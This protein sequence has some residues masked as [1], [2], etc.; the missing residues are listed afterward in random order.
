MEILAS[1]REFN[2]HNAKSVR[3]QTF[4]SL[5]TNGKKY[6]LGPFMAPFGASAW[7][8][9]LSLD[10]TVGDGFDALDGD[11]MRLRSHWAA[12]GILLSGAPLTGR[13]CD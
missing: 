10:L 7:D 1:A 8:K 5:T 3:G 2:V 12:S 6:T 13:A 11:S 4:A 9:R